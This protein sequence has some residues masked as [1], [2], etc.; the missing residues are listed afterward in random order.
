VIVVS[1]LSSRIQAGV[2]YVIL[3]L[4]GAVILISVL[5][6]L[7]MS[8]EGVSKVGVG[9]TVYL[10]FSAFAC[11]GGLLGFIFGLPRGRFADQVEATELRKAQASEPGEVA[12]TSHFLGN[13]NLIKVS[14]WLTTIL[15]GLGLVNLKSV[16]PA[17]ERL[18]EILASPL[19]GAAYSST[20]GLAM[21][22]T[23]LLSGFL[24]GY[25][26]T[27]LKY[28]EL[29]EEAES[30]YDAPLPDLVN[31]TVQ[32]AEQIV[33]PMAHELALPSDAAPNDLITSQDPDPGVRAVPGKRITVKIQKSV[34]APGH[35]T[36]HRA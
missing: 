10:L 33:G 30:R 32:E 20:V 35:A 11:G 9:L 19:G 23:G 16:I 24:L 4:L 15:L 12:H 17:V 18:S 5:F 22:L 26:W 31:K 34:H 29:L 7:S 1:A 36:D 8:D 28:R 6:A 13:S 3:S 27:T 21:C 14:D 2:T 25:L